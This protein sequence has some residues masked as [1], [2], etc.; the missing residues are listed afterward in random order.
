[1]LLTRAPLASGGDLSLPP[2]A[3]RLACVKPAASVHPEP[4]SNSPL[5]VYIVS[6]FLLLDGDQ[7][8]PCC[9]S[10]PAFPFIV[11]L[12]CLSAIY[13]LTETESS[14]PCLLVLSV[15]PER[16]SPLR[17]SCGILSMFSPLPDKPS[18]VPRLRLQNYNQNPP[19]ANVFM[20]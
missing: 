19:C 10:G 18:G 14:V 1:M 17:L 8:S 9:L 5:L 3:A 6:Y 11:S 7:K 16:I 4:G 13:R 20:F 2:A 12:G 15:W